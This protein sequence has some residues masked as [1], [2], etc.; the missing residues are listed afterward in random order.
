MKERIVKLM[1]GVIKVAVYIAFLSIIGSDLLALKKRRTSFEILLALLSIS[2]V[3]FFSRFTVMFNA[4]KAIKTCH[5]AAVLGS[6]YPQLD[7][8]LKRTVS[9][10][11]A[12]QGK[13]Q[14]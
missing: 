5:D 11:M 2:K 6:R 7:D 12:G 3:S 4:W 1:P 10:G 9:T 13:A 14:F 8:F